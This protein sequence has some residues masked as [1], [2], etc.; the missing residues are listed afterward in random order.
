MRTD[1]SCA[2]YETER[3]EILSN[4]LIDC[5]M[6]RQ[7]L[8]SRFAGEVA[9]SPTNHAEAPTKSSF[10]GRAPAQP[11]A[12]VRGWRRRLEYGAGRC[13]FR[14]AAHRAD[15]CRAADSW[16]KGIDLWVCHDSSSPCWLVGSF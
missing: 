10:A 2:D 16:N 9:E 12:G 5:E 8:L 11:A 13:D 6:G 4:R 14:Q 1:L 7:I 3:R 15:G